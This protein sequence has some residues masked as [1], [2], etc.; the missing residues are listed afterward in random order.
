MV[1]IFLVDFFGWL[2]WKNI[3]IFSAKPLNLF[4]S[5]LCLP[6]VALTTLQVGFG[7]FRFPTVLVFLAL[8]F[9]FSALT[10]ASFVR[11]IQLFFKSKRM[12]KSG[13]KNQ[14]RWQTI[15]DEYRLIGGLFILLLLMI[16]LIILA[17]LDI[18]ISTLIGVLIAIMPFKAMPRLFGR[19]KDDNYKITNEGKRWAAIVKCIGGMISLASIL[20]EVGLQ[21]L[22]RLSIINKS[23]EATRWDKITIMIAAFAIAII[24]LMLALFIYRKKREGDKA[25]F[26]EKKPP[27]R[28]RRHRRR[29]FERKIKR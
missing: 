3:R 23:S 10:L 25:W 18:T 28:I 29:T 27:Q 13:G 19:G 6:M 7:G 20:Y 16:L 14:E 1:L 4:F 2:V 11:F 8:A 24:P 22:V 15:Y 26:A 9:L 12:L 17:D 5:L 21:I